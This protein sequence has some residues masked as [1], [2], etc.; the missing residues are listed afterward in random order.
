MHNFRKILFVSFAH[1][2]E[3]NALVQA[4][5]IAHTNQGTLKMLSLYP[6]F[7]GDMALH[8]ASYQQFLQRS[9]SEALAKARQVLNLSAQQVPVSIEIEQGYALSLRII[10]HVLR[11]NYDLLIKTPEPRASRRGLMAV[12]MELLRKCPI[13]VWLSKPINIH[14]RKARIAVAVDP[15]TD[16]TEG[17]ALS[18]HELVVARALSDACDGMLRVVSCWDFPHEAYLRGNAWINIS[19]QQLAQEVRK[20]KENSHR[21]LN[22][23]ITESAIGGRIVVHHLRGLPG[24]VIADFIDREDIH[25]LVMGTVARTGI[26]GF[27]MGNTAENILQKLSCSLLALKPPGFVSPVRAY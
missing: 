19:D 3:E 11:E 17:H 22:A 13:P 15:R 18:L 9:A 5:S 14:R 20:A 10:R 1:A 2:D 21:L 4:L 24:E 12:D 8:E 25:V 26:P 23:L 6:P 7:S 16:T 27:V